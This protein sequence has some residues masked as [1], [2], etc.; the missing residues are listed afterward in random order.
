MM[1]RDYTSF[2]LRP[3]L[4]LVTVLLFGCLLSGL[5]L[6]LREKSVSATP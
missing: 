5:A 1:T 3:R 2:A 6:R 4:L